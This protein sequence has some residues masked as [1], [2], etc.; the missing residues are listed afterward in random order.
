[1][2]C[3]G[4]LKQIDCTQCSCVL[5]ALQLA[6]LVLACLA[7]GTAPAAEAA[8]HLKHVLFRKVAASNGDA[9]QMCC[10]HCVWQGDSH[11]LTHTSADQQ[12]MQRLCR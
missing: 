9:E 6:E 11:G 5:Q 8:V 7:K 2:L 12:C 10:W 1:M 4:V 3:K